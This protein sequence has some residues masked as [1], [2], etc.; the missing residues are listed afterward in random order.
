MTGLLRH[1]GSAA[2]LTLVFI[3]ASVDLGHKI[4]LQNTVFK[5]YEGDER[6]ILTAA[7][8]ALIIIPYIV[9][10]RLAGR[11]SDSFS[12]RLVLRISS[13]LVLIFALLICV[14]YALGYFWPAYAMTLLLGAQSAFFGPAKLAYLRGLYPQGVLASANG[15]AQAVVIIAILFASMGFSILFESLFSESLLVAA[16]ILPV[17]QPI[18]YVLIGCSLL[19][20]VVATRLPD[21]EQDRLINSG[22]ADQSMAADDVGLPGDDYQEG[23]PGPVSSVMSD[24]L[25]RAAI[26]G[27]TMFWSSG[28]VLLAIFPDHYASMTG[29]RNTAVIQAIMACLAVGTGIGAVLTG[30]LAKDGI[31]AHLLPFASAGLVLAILLVKL[32]TGP[33]LAV[34]AFFFA[35]LMGGVFII[36][37]YTLIQIYVHGHALGRVLAINNL[38]QNC[39]MLAFLLATVL[40]ALYQFDAGTILT[41]LLIYTLACSLYCCTRL[42]KV[43]TILKG[44]SWSL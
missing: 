22:I 29:E 6:I 19:Q 23:N 21:V 5:L 24:R 12:R 43:D 39:F 44:P 40:A 2:F 27:L 35:G 42:R 4:T 25:L 11:V 20:L 36:P 18:A 30:R 16:D 15:F 14:L 33:Y 9:F 37:L 32:V 7:L 26:L 41:G 28:Q 3:N 17:M 34:L 8:N 31:G 13:L 10:F 1:R 38:I